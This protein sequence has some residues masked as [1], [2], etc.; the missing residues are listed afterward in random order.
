V[1]DWIAL[2]KARGESAIQQSRGRKKYMLH[3]DRQR[4]LAD[5]ELRARLKFLEA[6][7]DYLKKSYSLIQEKD[8]QSKKK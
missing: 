6:E 2:C 5:N 8:K 3:E 7:N 1:N 4:Y